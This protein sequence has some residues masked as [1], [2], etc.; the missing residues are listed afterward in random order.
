MPY[1]V[2]AQNSKGKTVATVVRN[3]ESEGE[4]EQYIL[5]KHPDYKILRVYKKEEPAP[6]V[7]TR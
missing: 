2:V 3:V 6:L 1:V 4:A 5:D 7:P